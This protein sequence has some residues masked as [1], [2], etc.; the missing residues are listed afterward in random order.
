MQATLRIYG[1]YLRSATTDVAG[2]S[3]LVRQ[4]QWLRDNGITKVAIG[5]DPRLSVMVLQRAI[6]LDVALSGR[7]TWVKDDGS[8]SDVKFAQRVGLDVAGPLV[9]VPGNVLGGVDLSR[10]VP[11]TRKSVRVMLQ[12]LDPP[13]PAAARRASRFGTD[14]EPYVDILFDGAPPANVIYAASWGARVLTIRDGLSLAVHALAGDLP[15]RSDDNLSKIQIHAAEREPGIWLAR[16]A[17]VEPGAR[18]LA[19]VL[20]GPD[21]LVCAGATVGEGSVVSHAA[22]VE[23]D[24]VVLGSFVSEGMIV[25]EG[26]VLRGQCANDSV[27]VDLASGTRAPLADRLLLDRR[28][29]RSFQALPVTQFVMA[30]VKSP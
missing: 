13:P 14:D 25:G 18:L 5:V 28:V 3:F 7:V 23:R 10:F 19:P 20:L 30:A 8:E 21:A 9:C 26:L 15:A 24:A 16:G 12:R 27:L 29:R 17:K 6:R 2:R 4:L 1:P 11:K 22:V